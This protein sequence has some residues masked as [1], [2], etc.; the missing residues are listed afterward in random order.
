MVPRV[1]KTIFGSR[2]QCWHEGA[3]RYGFYRW[4]TVHSD[5]KLSRY[6]STYS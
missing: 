1:V 6:L 2:V 3:E 5:K 4:D